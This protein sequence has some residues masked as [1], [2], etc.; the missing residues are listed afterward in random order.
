M[1]YS[2]VAGGENMEGFLRVEVRHPNWNEN[3]DV[4][5]ISKDVLRYAAGILYILNKFEKEAVIEKVGESIGYETV[6]VEDNV[7]QTEAFQ[8]SVKYRLTDGKRT[9][10]ISIY[11]PPGIMYGVLRWKVVL[12]AKYQT[13]TVDITIYRDET[14]IASSDEIVVNYFCRILHHLIKNAEALSERVNKFKGVAYVDSDGTFVARSI[15]GDLLIFKR[16]M[17]DAKLEFYRRIKL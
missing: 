14:Y 1:Y 7:A 5:T 2:R 9:L 17:P 15:S 6:K 8:S 10:S 12:E 11:H 16:G 3:F 13:P 4:K